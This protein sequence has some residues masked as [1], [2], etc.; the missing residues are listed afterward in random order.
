MTKPQTQK[1]IDF[2][3]KIKLDYPIEWGS[4]IRTEIQINRRLKLK[5]LKGLSMETLQSIDGILEVCS[6]LTGEPTALLEELDPDDFGKIG[7]HLGDF[8]ANGLS[9]GRPG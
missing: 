8:F 4:D 1:K 7:G 6:K 9:T 3:I 5:D 2:P